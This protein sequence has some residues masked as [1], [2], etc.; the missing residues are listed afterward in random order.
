MQK[1]MNETKIMLV[2]SNVDLELAMKIQKVI[3]EHNKG[4]D[5]E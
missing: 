4:K 3:K 5:H 1:T 2:I